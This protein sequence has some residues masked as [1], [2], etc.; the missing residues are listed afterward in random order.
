MRN[1]IRPKA[2]LTESSGEVA[3]EVPRD[4]QGTF[5]TQIVCKRRRRL[6]G[7]DEIWPGCSG[8]QTYLPTAT[9][10]MSSSAGCYRVRTCSLACLSAALDWYQPWL[11]RA[12]PAFPTSEKTTGDWHSAASI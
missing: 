4:R 11:V 3:L 10:T 9:A 1:G 7:V 2:V 8:V 5:E 6:N 12:P